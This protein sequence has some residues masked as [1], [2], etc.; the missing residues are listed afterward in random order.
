MGGLP[1]GSDPDD[2]A[3]PPDGPADRIPGVEDR[4]RMPG[5]VVPIELEI[6]VVEQ[7]LPL[8]S[9]SDLCRLPRRRQHLGEEVSGRGQK[10]VRE[11]LAQGMERDQHA[12]ITK[13]RLLLADSGTGEQSLMRGVDG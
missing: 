9:L 13:Q 2:P 3:Q 5:V 11:H 12:A 10:A 4:K 1:V 8:E 7:R 6:P